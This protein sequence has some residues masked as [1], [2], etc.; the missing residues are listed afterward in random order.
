M[1]IKNAGKYLIYS[2]I[3]DTVY[4]GGEKMAGVEKMYNQQMGFD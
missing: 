4:A 2:T 3:Y 1:L